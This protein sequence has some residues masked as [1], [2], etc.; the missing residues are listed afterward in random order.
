MLSAREFSLRDK[1]GT[2]NGMEVVSVGKG[3]AVARFEVKDHHKN[4]L[5]TVHGGALFTLADLAFAAATNCG[6]EITVSINAGMSFSKACTD[7]V[8]TVEAREVARSPKL[9]N[10]EAKVCNEA[11]EIMAFFHGTGYIKY[12]TTD[13][14]KS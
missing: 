11:G 12:K 14:K 2:Y 9:V 7:G 5:G 3:V 1:F 8:L 10:Y 6:E 4:G 13:Q